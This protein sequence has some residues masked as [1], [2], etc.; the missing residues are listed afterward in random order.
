MPR[1]SPI[2]SAEPLVNEGIAILRSNGADAQADAVATVLQ[3]AVAQVK[4]RK[5][6]AMSGGKPIAVPLRPN[7]YLRAYRSDVNLTKLV[8]E[9]WKAFQASEWEPVHPKPEFA[10]ESGADATGR[11][12]LNIRVPE[13]ALEA[14][15]DAAS[16][17]VAEHDWPTKRGYRL[18]ARHVAAQWLALQ[19]PA[20]E[21]EEAAAE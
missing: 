4:Q 21:Q 7:L 3:Y 10:L 14:A 18:T 6:R 16:A 13:E 20:D 1:K 11:A 12:M 19:F 17:W 15:E 8:L 2:T 9:G 5:S